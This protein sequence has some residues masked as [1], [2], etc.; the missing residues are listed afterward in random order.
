MVVKGRRSPE[1]HAKNLAIAGSRLARHADV[2]NA[3]YDSDL[4]VAK[5]AVNPYGGVIYT[6]A[7]TK[8]HATIETKEVW[9]IDFLGLQ[10]IFAV[11]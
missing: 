6:G 8:E 10:R 1:P 11:P 9:T 5:D 4:V 3:G 7:L 2:E